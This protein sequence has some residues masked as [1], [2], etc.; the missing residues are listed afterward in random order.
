MLSAAEPQHPWLH[1]EP[2]LEKEAA[3]P[4]GSWSSTYPAKCQ[5]L[6]LIHLAKTANYRVSQLS[7][8]VQWIYHVCGSM[9]LLCPCPCPCPCCFPAVGIATNVWSQYARHRMP[10][11]RTVPCTWDENLILG[12][13]RVLASRQRAQLHDQGRPSPRPK[14]RKPRQRFHTC[15]SQADM[16]SYQA[17]PEHPWRGL[18]EHVAASLHPRQTRMLFGSP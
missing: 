15:M 10:V 8:A 2:A 6:P 12:I 16:S 13:L 5:P 11:L 4:S 1:T 7:L 18:P 14:Y 17:R 9:L 3:S